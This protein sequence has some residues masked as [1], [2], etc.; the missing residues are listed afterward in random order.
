VNEL[1]VLTEAE[2]AKLFDCTPETVQERTRSGDL[3]GIKLGVSWR[4]P[5]GALATALDELALQE[6]KQRKKKPIPVPAAGAKQPAKRGG[7]SLP[8]LSKVTAAR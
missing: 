6:A 1:K 2:V 4:Y 7:K 5:A 3:P 8:D